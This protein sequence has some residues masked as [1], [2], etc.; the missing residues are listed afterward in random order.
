MPSP[1]INSDSIVQQE[2]D[3][4]RSGFR[5]WLI[6][7][8]Q[9]RGI[10]MSEGTAEAILDDIV[11]PLTK[12]RRMLAEAADLEAHKLEVDDLAHYFY[13]AKVSIFVRRASAEFQYQPSQEK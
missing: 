5:K 10:K 3:F 4:V 12:A 2:E 11:S 1:E 7:D 6:E 13:D 9:R 8:S